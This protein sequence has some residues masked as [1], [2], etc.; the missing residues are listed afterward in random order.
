MANVMLTDS[1]IWWR[2]RLAMFIWQPTRVMLIPSGLDR[3]AP[4]QLWVGIN[5]TNEML[6]NGAILSRLLQGGVV[7]LGLNRMALWWRWVEIKKD[8]AM[9][10]NGLI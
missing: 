1:V 8:N 10:A 2:S 3:M 9:S 4:W 5:M 6:A 7:P